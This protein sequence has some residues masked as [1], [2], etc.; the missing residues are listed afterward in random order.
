MK[1]DY[2]KIYDNDIFELKS[3]VVGVNVSDK[4]LLVVLDKS[5]FR[6]SSGGQPSDN[7]FLENE[8][9]KGFVEEVVDKGDYLVH[10]V[11]LE[12]GS[13]KQ[14]DYVVAR[15]NRERR[16]KLKRMH[17]SEHIFAKALKKFDDNIV[18]DK[19]SLSEDE[20]SIFVKA[21]TLDWDLLF[22]AEEIVNKIISENRYFRIHYAG[23]EEIDD[24]IDKGLRIKKDKIKDDF[25]RIVEVENF[26]IS[27]CTGTHVKNS[28]EI[29]SFIVTGFK[30]LGK[31][32]FQIRFIAGNTRELLFDYSREFRKLRTL[33]G[34]Q[35]IFNTAKKQITD[36]EL[37]KNKYYYYFSKFLLSMTPDLINNIRF[38][39]FVFENEDQKVLIRNSSK[40]CSERTLVCF[41]NKQ[42]NYYNLILMASKDLTVNLK[43]LFQ[44]EVLTVCNGK[45]GG[46]PH[47]IIGRLECENPTLILDKVK[48]FVKS[49]FGN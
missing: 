20:S 39:S 37:L 41:L 16:Q 6:P 38:Y 45:A 24:W 43:E 9:F 42:G 4:T 1:Q 7:G 31:N 12:R 11:K 22:K 26:D 25:V 3:R 21:E 33:F 8:N 34:E 14:G 28:S 48:S 46:N 27:A 2:F 30:N 23:K 19:I 44:R 17:S 15:I 35:D 29:N 13:L 5:P 47:Y 40:L 10:K 36:K 18:L 49:K 32:T